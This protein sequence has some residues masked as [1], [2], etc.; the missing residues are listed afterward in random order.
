[1][2][3]WLTNPV[4]V[5]AAIGLT[6]TLLGAIGGFIWKTARWVEKV[7]S[8]TSGL[9]ELAEEIRDNLREIRTHINDILGRLPPP[10]TV[11][12]GSPVQLTEFGREVAAKLQ[13]GEWG[14]QIAP[15]LAKRLAG[16]QP[17]EIDDFTRT[18]VADELS[19]NSAWGVRIAECAYEF[20]IDQAGVRAVMQVVLRDEI[21]RILES[22]ES[23]T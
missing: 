11:Q 15:R 21:L 20:G 19:P 4:A 23:G 17:F 1:M 7:D 2:D 16:K 6:L 10:R 3:D 8:Q 12:N 5:V 18:Y 14:S 13:A 9:R 22:K